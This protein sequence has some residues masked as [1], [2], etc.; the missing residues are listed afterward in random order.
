MRHE[1]WDIQRSTVERCR[2]IRSMMD[3]EP[4][5]ALTTA[6]GL[7]GIGPPA[8]C[9]LDV[10]MH[11]V[12]HRDARPHRHPAG[13][14]VHVWSRLTTGMLTL[15][16]GLLCTT[17]AATFA[18]LA[19]YCPYD[20]LIM[21]ADRLTCRDRLLARASWDDLHDF[22]ASCPRLRNGQV[23]RRAVNLSRPGTDSPFECRLRLGALQ[24][25]LP[26]PI[27]NHAV[28]TADGGRMFLDMAYPEYR[29][30]MEFHGRHHLEQYRQDT[31][32][33]N[34]LNASGWSVFQAWSETLFD[35]TKRNVFYGNV[36]D[37]LS[38]AGAV[39]FMNPV[40]DLWALGDGRRT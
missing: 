1:A 10:D 16:Y 29:V 25:G 3:H 34:D 22:V 27:V 8:G 5:F 32:R 11:V 37:A 24:Y 35:E 36:S 17:P 6:L 26:E 21:L 15:V 18:Q 23:A 30:G 13:V 4:V 31:E 14:D 9:L 12:R 38:A 33:L 20:S 39:D 2:R 19:R 40:R 28:E 7:F